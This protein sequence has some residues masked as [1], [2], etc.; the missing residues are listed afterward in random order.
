M[1]QKGTLSCRGNKDRC[2]EER[3]ANGRKGGGAG[4]AERDLII[5]VSELSQK[6]KKSEGRKKEILTQKKKS[7]RVQ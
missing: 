4:L 5:G 3:F 2:S 1:A 7:D 6:K